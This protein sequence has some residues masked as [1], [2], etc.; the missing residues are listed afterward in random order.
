MCPSFACNYRGCHEVARVG[1]HLPTPQR[2]PRQDHRTSEV[3]R[4]RTVIT[5]HRGIHGGVAV[6]AVHGQDCEHR[7]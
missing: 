5:H 4:Q 6:G 7:A 3:Q 1:V 2:P